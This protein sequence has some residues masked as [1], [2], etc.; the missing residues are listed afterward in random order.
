[1]GGSFLKI[2]LQ[3][4]KEFAEGAMQL[5]GTERVKQNPVTSVYVDSLI[6][7]NK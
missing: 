3:A 4:M 5:E 1:M 7:R 6:D 2:A